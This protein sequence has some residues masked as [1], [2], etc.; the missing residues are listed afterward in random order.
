MNTSSGESRPS[1]VSR[2]VRTT[3][4]GWLLGLVLVV[5][6][7]VVWD[8]VGG[9]AQFMVGLG[10]GAGV[11]YAQGRMIGAWIDSPRRW[12]WSSVAGMGVPFLLWDLSAAGDVPLPFSLPAAALMGALLVGILQWR[13]LRPRSNRAVWWVPACIVGWGV[14][15]VGLRL[16]DLAVVPAP[17]A[18]LLSIGMMFFG[19]IVLG[20]V[21][22]KVLAWIFRPS[23]ADAEGG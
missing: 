6:L 22:G 5:L 19:G 17:M 12:L 13:L 15:T 21:T 11:G 9:G 16:N 20:L 7:A 23:A 2:W 1:L 3:A 18:Y 4:W 10:M 8:A 14:P